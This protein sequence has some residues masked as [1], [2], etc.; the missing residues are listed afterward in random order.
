MSWNID[1]SQ[2]CNGE[3]SIANF[4]FWVLKEFSKMVS[5]IIQFQQ[6][7]FSSFGENNNIK[8]HDSSIFKRILER[9]CQKRKWITS[10]KW[11]MWN[12]LYWMSRIKRLNHIWMSFKIVDRWIFLIEHRN[13]RKIF[14]QLQTAQNCVYVEIL[15]LFFCCCFASLTMT[16]FW[17]SFI[18]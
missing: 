16:I 14:F 7:S 2:K 17:V 18:S 6:L 12:V 13:M 8:Q 1:S 15:W 5:R 3:G 9:N 10:E 4:N 11:W